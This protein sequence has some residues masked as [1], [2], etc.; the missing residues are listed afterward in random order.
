ML[1]AYMDDALLHTY[2]A[3]YIQYMYVCHKLILVGSFAFY[4]NN[5]LKLMKNKP[6]SFPRLTYILLQNIHNH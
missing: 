6:L 4:R 2:T 1:Q 5:P 3:T